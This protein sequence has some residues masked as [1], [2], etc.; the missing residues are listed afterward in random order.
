MRQRHRL[1]DEPVDA[2]PPGRG[3]EARIRPVDGV[4]PPAL[5][6]RQERADGLGHQQRRL[7]DEIERAA[8]PRERRDADSD[9]P[10]ERAPAGVHRATV[11]LLGKP[12]RLRGADP[13]R[14]RDHRAVAGRGPR[15]PRP[16]AARRR[17]HRHR[18]D[19]PEPPGHVRGRRQR[20]DQ[21]RLR[22][23]DQPRDGGR[24]GRLPA[25]GD[26]LP[27]ARRA[28]ASPPATSPSTTRPRA[29]S[30]SSSRTSPARCRA[31]RSPAAPRPRPRRRCAALAAVHQPV[32]GD[33]HVGSKPWLN[34]ESPLNQALLRHAA[35]G[36]PRALRRPRR[37]RAPRR[38]RALRHRRR[39][40]A[41]RPPAAARARPRRLPARQPP[42][43]RRTRARWWTGRR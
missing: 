41:G 30:R 33:L 27:G 21:A 43:R 26:L 9:H 3:V 13:D 32:I 22:R 16:R 38:V 37:A 25:R 5:A 39:R 19:E 24:H 36:L 31:T 15:P 34:Q 23:R 1:R 17:A 40:L 2:Q 18:A 28:R 7:V 6:E 29:G 11:R 10:Q 42:L 12:L 20:G 4:D 8:A 35:P 14:R